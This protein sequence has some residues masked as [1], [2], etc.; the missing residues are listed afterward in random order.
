MAQ[1][2]YNPKNAPTGKGVVPKTPGNA[3]KVPGPSNHI[4]E[5]GKGNYSSEQQ[6]GQ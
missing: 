1:A 6:Q 5:L 3:G 2:K 4:P